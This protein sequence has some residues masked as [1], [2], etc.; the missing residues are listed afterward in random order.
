MARTVRPKWGGAQ[1]MDCVGSVHRRDSFAGPLAPAWGDVSEWASTPSGR[2]EMTFRIAR[3]SV[4]V[5]CLAC[6]AGS[7]SPAPVSAQRQWNGVPPV[8]VADLTLLHTAHQPD[9]L[10][11]VV[12]R[13]LSDASG[14]A[15]LPDGDILV[16]E[17]AGTLRII[18]DGLLDPEPLVEIPVN[19]GLYS[20]LTEVVLHPDFERNGL[21]YMTYANPGQGTGI[22]LAR[23]RYDGTRL[24]DLETVFT[25]AGRGLAASGSELIWAPDGTL[26]MS[27]GGAFNIGRTGGLAQER[28]DHAGKI[29][30]LTAEGA[31]APGNPFIGDSE[32]LPEIYTLGHRNVMGFAFDPS[33]GDLWAAEH[34]PQ[35][36]DEVNVILPGHNYG[37]PIVSYGRDYGGT[38]VTQEWY[39]E[40]FDTPT[41]VWLPSIAPAGMMF[42]TGDRF[43]AWRG[44]LFVG[45]LMVGR[46]E[47][48]GHIE[49]VVLNEDGEEVARE[50][51]LTELRQRIRDLHQGPD[52]F[53]YALT[54]EDDGTGLLLRIEP[55]GS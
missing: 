36:G 51:I 7:W 53:I 22:A 41:V 11:R 23:A 17:K 52:G 37:W 44:N 12:A 38:R 24:S 50:P 21:I 54:D 28:K 9:I 4:A 34:A 55:V 42:Y 6:C 35:G 48:T 3:H 30:H 19:H 43:P 49:R 16:T 1:K 45:A 15:F 33:T 47:R 13:G 5:I 8:E 20:G 40:G 46:I 10:V 39:H 31:P 2:V 27:V 18:R 25:T 14:F 29:L 26:F 32:Y